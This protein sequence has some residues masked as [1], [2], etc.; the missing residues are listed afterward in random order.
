MAFQDYSDSARS[1]LHLGQVRPQVIIGISAI[2]IA[3]LAVLLMGLHA[4]GEP[5]GFQVSKAQAQETEDG[6][7]DDGSNDRGNDGNNSSST[8]TIR[9]HVAGCVMCPGVYEL[10]EGSRA[11]DA[12]QAAGGLTEDACEDAINLA[13]VISDG[14]QIIAPSSREPTTAISA[15]SSTSST[16]SDAGQTGKVNINTADAAQLQTISGI[17]ESKAKKI[18]AY[19]EAN[20]RF[21]N[22]DELVNVSGIGDK[23]LDSIRDQIC[24]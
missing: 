8:S 16:S 21:S 2:A 19:R 13:Q 20:G 17:G 12:V 3:A 15:M 5:E 23:T 10:V 6:I 9:V 24:A 14:E 4:L 1:R 11:G 7:A 22:V 18:I